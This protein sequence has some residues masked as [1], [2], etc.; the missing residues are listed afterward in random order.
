MPS[1]AWWGKIN[2]AMRLAGEREIS[3]EEVAE[4]IKESK[5]AVVPTETV[6]G[7]AASASEEGAYRALLKA[8]GQRRAPLA[9]H[10]AEPEEAL[11]FVRPNPRFEA[12][13]RA[14]MPGPLT[15]VAEAGG[16]TPPHLVASDGSVGVRCPGH[17]FVRSCIRLS[18][19]IL[20]PSANRAGSL[21]PL[22]VEEAISEVGEH[23]EIAIDGG[24]SPGGL[25]STVVDT[26]G[27]RARILRPGLV[28]L[29]AI[30]EVLGEEVE[31]VPPSPE[32][33]YLRRARLI[34]V[35]ARGEE[36]VN[37]A[38]EWRGREGVA[39]LVASETARLLEGA[40][41][42]APRSRPDLAAKNLYS[43]LRRLDAE[44]RLIICEDFGEEGLWRAVTDRLIRSASEVVED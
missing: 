3:P 41:A 37:R 20:L 43:L 12:L 30:R 25:E 18:G 9:V 38:E 2:L 1:P 42:L 22:T 16:R 29:E 5:L 7:L 23:C 40:V 39:F 35:K 6:Y 15:L 8:K 36:F 32:G 17:D 27:E 19:P 34:F 11:E 14:L 13:C 24:T 26:R 33:R 21:P 10:V 28:N 31:C 44:G 4:V